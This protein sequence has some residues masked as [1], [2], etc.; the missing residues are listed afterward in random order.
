MGKLLNAVYYNLREPGGFGGIQAL[1]R[2]TGKSRSAICKFLQ[3]EDAYTL[4]KPTRIRFSRRRTYTKGINDLF[5]ADLVDVSS[6]S[7]YNDG[8]RY[9]LTCIDVFSKTAWAL[10]LK[11]KSGLE[12]TAVFESILADRK[13]NMLQTDKGTEWLNSTFQAMLRKYN[14]KF[15]TSEN[16]DIKAAVVERFNRTLKSKMWRYFTHK[17]TRR[18]VDVLPD[19]LYSYNNTYHRSIGMKPSDVHTTNENKVRKRLYP[20]K[21][22]RKPKWKLL[23]DDKVRISM[24][25]RPFKKGYIGGWSEE[26]FVVDARYPTQPVTYRIKDLAGETIK[27]KFYEPELQKILKRDDIYIIEKIV[28]T[29]KRAGAIEYFVKWRGYSDKFNSWVSDVKTA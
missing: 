28:K 25:R 11:T 27:G 4:H 7:K 21:S 22:K 15:Y 19:L 12:V 5:Q 24:Q 16:D 18:F 14:I 13:C 8:Y 3:G 10:P 23:V 26:I 17:N 29:R 6:I 1:Q 2:H 9:I 20:L